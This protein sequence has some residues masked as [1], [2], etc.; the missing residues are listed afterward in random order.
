MPGPGVYLR[1]PVLV[2][3]M[4]L[5]TMTLSP[6][7]S[8]APPAR[9]QVDSAGDKVGAGE[10]PRTLPEG[11]SVPILLSLLPLELLV[12]MPRVLWGQVPGDE[13]SY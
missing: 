6:T 1:V 2:P 8:A 11:L 4:L 13:G 10:E 7:L 12:S 3:A 5:A 9:E